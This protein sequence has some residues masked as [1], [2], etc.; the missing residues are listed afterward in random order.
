MKL[1]PSSPAGPPPARVSFLADPGGLRFCSTAFD[2]EADPPIRRS[3]PMARSPSHPIAR[4]Q[5]DPPPSIGETGAF[6]GTSSRRWAVLQAPR[7]LGLRGKQVRSAN[8]PPPR[9]IIF[10]PFRE[11]CTPLR[12]VAR[13]VFRSCGKSFSAAREPQIVSQR[14]SSRLALSSTHSRAPQPHAISKRY[15]SPKTRARRG[16][17]VRQGRPWHPRLHA[18]ARAAGDQRGP[19]S[20]VQGTSAATNEQRAAQRWQQRDGQRAAHDATEQRANASR[21]HS[22]PCPAPAD[23]RSTRSH[24]E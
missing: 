7:R 13:R 1:C 16:L 14:R 8:L 23:D 21:P 18:P 9:K 3:L 22:P 17:G 5:R 4:S 10:P 24:H 12:A 11:R 15:V 19:A 6:L 20:A 2:T